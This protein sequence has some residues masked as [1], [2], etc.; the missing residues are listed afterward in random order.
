MAN[1]STSGAVGGVATLLA[2]GGSVNLYMGFGGTNAGFTSGANGG[3]ADFQPVITSYDYNS[4]IQ[5]GGGHGYGPGDGDKFQAFL[6][7][8]AYWSG[9]APAPEPPAP[10]VTAY[11]SVTM[12]SGCPLLS[13]VS[14]LAGASAAHGLAAPLTME[15]LGQRHG[16]ALYASALPAGATPGKA[17]K[18]VLAGLADRAEAFVG[19]A[20]AGVTYRPDTGAGTISVAG[21]L[22]APGAQLGVLVENCGHIN[23][24]R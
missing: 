24:G 4:P 14:S 11:G 15:A 12:S 20:S 10:A 6:Q 22:V 3:G 5:E 8:F 17:A 16:Y 1:T 23:Y 19:G 13:V 2:E 7:L 18:L 21:S 9:V